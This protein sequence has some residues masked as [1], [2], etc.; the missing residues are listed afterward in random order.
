MKVTIATIA[1]FLSFS[2]FSRGCDGDQINDAIHEHETIT[3]PYNNGKFEYTIQDIE[4]VKKNGNQ[5]TYDAILGY[6]YSEGGY[7]LLTI[8]AMATGK[9]CETKIIITDET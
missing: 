7:R 3:D 6:E 5:S 8:E 2:S 4:L 1:I 9:E